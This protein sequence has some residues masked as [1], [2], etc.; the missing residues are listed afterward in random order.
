MIK[1]FKLKLIYIESNKNLIANFIYF[2]ITIKL[3][4][5]IIDSKWKII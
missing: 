3:Y 4:K 1:N 2:Y 5:I